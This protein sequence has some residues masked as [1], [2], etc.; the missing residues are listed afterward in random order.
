MSD[1][2]KYN[3]VFPHDDQRSREQ[4]YSERGVSD[5]FTICSV[6]QISVPLVMYVHALQSFKRATTQA[7]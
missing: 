3:A 5:K 1:S 7:A 6:L 4:H 2:R